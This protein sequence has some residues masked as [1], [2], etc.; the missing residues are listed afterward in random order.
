MYLYYIVTT[1][2]T[3]EVPAET[4]KEALRLA[5]YPDYTEIRSMPITEETLLDSGEFDYDHDLG[6]VTYAIKH[7]VDPDGDTG[8][9][10]LKEAKNEITWMLDQAQEIFENATRIENFDEDAAYDEWRCNH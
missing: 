1:N 10:S 9:N 7:W 8:Y 6:T 5:L 3:I 4:E 2:G